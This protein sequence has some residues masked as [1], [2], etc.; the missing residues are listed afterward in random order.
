MYLKVVWVDP[1]DGTSEFA[2]GV[3]EHSSL[4]EQVTMLI[5]IGDKRTRRPIAGLIYQPFYGFVK[6]KPYEQMGRVVWSIRGC[7]V[8]GM[9]AR[10]AQAGE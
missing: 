7:G 5:G 9:Q 10:K 1:V 2:Q 4:L 3:R 6:D 8:H